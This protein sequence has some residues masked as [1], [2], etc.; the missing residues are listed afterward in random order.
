M[1][2]DRSAVDGRVADWR[3]KR[4]HGRPRI[5]FGAARN[6]PGPVLDSHLRLRRPGVWFGDYTVTLL[7]RIAILR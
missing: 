4:R 3:K 6:G 1:F 2:L 7:A 5:W